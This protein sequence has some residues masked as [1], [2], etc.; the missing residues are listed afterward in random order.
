MLTFKKYL[1]NKLIVDGII[2]IPQELNQQTFNAVVNYLAQIE[3]VG[4]NLVVHQT[5]SDI[6]HRIVT[7]QGFGSNTGLNGTALIIGA[8]NLGEFIKRMHQAHLAKQNQDFDAYYRLAAGNIHKGS[9]AIVVL[10]I[11]KNLGNLTKIDDR[12]TDLV[13]SG[14]LKSM[15]VPNQYIVGYWRADGDFFGNSKFNPQGIL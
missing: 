9:N 5:D 6:A 11:P 2:N 13:M 14:Q 3:N 4:F 10:A 7:S 12:L 15:Q 1:E 8:A